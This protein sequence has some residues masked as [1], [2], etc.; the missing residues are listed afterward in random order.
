VT[1]PSDPP[2]AAESL[3]VHAEALCERADHLWDVVQEL[4]VPTAFLT[5]TRETHKTTF[6][7]DPLVRAFLYQHIRDISENDL[8]TRLQTR[9]TL[10]EALHFDIS[11]LDE[12]PRQATL[13]H[14]WHSFSDDTQQ[15]IQAAAVGIRDVAVEKNVIAAELVPTDP[16]DDES[17]SAPDE[18]EANRQKT[19][20]TV[21]LARKHAFGAFDSGRAANRTYDDEEILDMI[22]RVCAHRGTAHSEGEYG[23]LTDDDGTASGSTVRRVIKQFATP[24]DEETQ[25]TLDEIATGSET[26][27]ID[28]IRDTV[29]DSFDEAVGNIVSSIRGEGPFSDRRKTAAIDITCEEVAVSPWVDKDQGLVKPD[30]PKMVSG[31]KDGKSYNRGYKYATITLAGELTPIILGVEP[32]KESSNWEDEEAAADAKAEV[33]ERLLAK[34]E[35][36]VDLD[37]VYLDRGFHSMAVHAAIDERDI[38]YTAPV[39]KY[40]DDLEAIENIKEHPTADAAVQHDVEVAL[41]GRVDHTAEYLY[42]PTDRDD[43]D[44]KYAVF[45]TNREHVEPAD[46]EAVCNRYRRR[47]DIENQYKS[48]EEFLPKTS[49][50]DYRMRFTKFVI[51]ALIYNLWRLTDY[52][53]KV[54]REKPIRSQ[55]ELSVKTFV[56]ALGDFLREIG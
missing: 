50:M 40:Q 7:T 41:D 5:D 48:L 38:L 1:T 2:H 31:Y 32:V 19:S 46:V 44:G 36:F 43:A 10:V 51:T 21:K 29:I 56:R 26:P 39:P 4:S 54:A 45:I 18:R 15:I 8:A 53:L 9:P 35:Q 12:A 47:W 33:V 55:P 30:Y 24:D 13:N 49:S 28:R 6:E 42:V 23:W 11:S 17:D 3:V 20:K 34:A 14:A 22:S 27:G 25:L 37:E 52:L 16:S